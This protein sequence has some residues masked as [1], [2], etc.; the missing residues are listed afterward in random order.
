M[1]ILT[2]PDFDATTVNHTTVTFEGASETHVDKKTGEPRR[3]EED[4]DN[5]GDTDLV[6]HFELGETD[7]TCDSVNGTLI[8]ETYDGVAIEGTDSVRMVDRGGG[9]GGGSGGGGGP[10]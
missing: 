5:D 6:L 4:V 2:T 9:S 8:G 3:H 7:L 1:A 10:P